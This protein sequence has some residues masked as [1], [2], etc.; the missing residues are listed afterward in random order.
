MAGAALTGGFHD[1]AHVQES[2]FFSSLLHAVASM[3][4]SSFNCIV[5]EPISTE[6][7]AWV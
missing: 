3:H 1:S 6:L 2:K 7:I 5:N 4:A